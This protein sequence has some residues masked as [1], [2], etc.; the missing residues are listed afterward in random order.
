M[1]SIDN[2]IEFT[3]GEFFGQYEPEHPENMPTV[4]I[5]AR[6]FYH[7]PVYDTFDLD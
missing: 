1:T 4:A 7:K 2:D 5:Q 6:A 3:G